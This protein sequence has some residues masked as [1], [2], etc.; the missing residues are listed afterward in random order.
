MSEDQTLGFEPIEF[1]LSRGDFENW[2]SSLGDIE[3]AR[4]LRLI[5]EK[6]LTG[7]ALKEKLHIAIRTRCDQLLKK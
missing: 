6:N 1:H 7:E 4:R 2:I 5:R 3:L